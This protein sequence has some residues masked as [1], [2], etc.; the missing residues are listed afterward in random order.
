MRRCLA[1]LSPIRTTIMPRRSN[2]KSRDWTVTVCL[3][4]DAHL[5]R[6]LAPLQTPSESAP[7]TGCGPQQAICFPARCFAPGGQLRRNCHIRSGQAGRQTAHSLPRPSSSLPS[8]GLGGLRP[9]GRTPTMTAPTTETHKKMPTQGSRSILNSLGELSSSF[10]FLT[11]FMQHSAEP[12]HNDIVTCV[13]D[14]QVMG[15]RVKA[16]MQMGTLSVAGRCHTL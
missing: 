2:A 15:R 6:V 8:P 14:N 3:E 1:A 13:T 9:A 11:C 10:A 5:L 12:G 16:I 4:S 7:P